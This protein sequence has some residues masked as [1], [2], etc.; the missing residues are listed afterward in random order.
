[1]S[2]S[3]DDFRQRLE[4]AMPIDDIVAWL[5]QQYPAASEPEIMG[6]LQRV[7][8]RGYKISPAARE[9]RNYSVGGQDWSAFPQ[10]VEATKP[11]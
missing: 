2:N 1:M 8:G 11:A 6:L 9:Q 4:A 3:E 7:Y 5:L 10:R